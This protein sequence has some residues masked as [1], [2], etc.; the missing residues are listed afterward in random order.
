MA[1][2]QINLITSTA[3]IQQQPVPDSDPVGGDAFTSSGSS[4]QGMTVAT[5]DPGADT[6]WSVTSSGGTV[7]VTFG[8]NPTAAAGTSWLV[9]DGQ[10]FWFR[11]VPG[12]KAAVIDA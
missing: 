8:T 9:P 1:T 4:Q 11:A 3:R 7:W 5:A 10:T 12:E 2:V 6:Y